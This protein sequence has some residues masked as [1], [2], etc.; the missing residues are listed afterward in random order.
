MVAVAVAA[1]ETMVAVEVVTAAEVVKEAGND[2][3]EVGKGSITGTSMVAVEVAAAEERVVRAAKAK[4]KAKA[5][6]GQ[7]SRQAVLVDQPGIL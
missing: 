7:I 3:A 4:A 6:E 2:R 1:A 5:R